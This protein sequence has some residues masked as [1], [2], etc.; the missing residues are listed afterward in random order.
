MKTTTTHKLTPSMAQEF[1]NAF[2][3]EEYIDGWKSSSFMYSPLDDINYSKTISHE[4]FDEYKFTD[5]SSI[6]IVPAQ[7]GSSC[8][9]M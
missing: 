1:A 2:V 3:T 9:V 5:G 7:V 4:M 6:M 8:Y